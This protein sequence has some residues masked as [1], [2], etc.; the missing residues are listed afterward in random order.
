MG[1]FQTLKP[2]ES[3]QKMENYPAYEYKI[4]FLSNQFMKKTY[5]KL[6]QSILK[7][8]NITVLMSCSLYFILYSSGVN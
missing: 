8:V 5:W 3:R 6:T 4:V 1:K 7:C 2:M